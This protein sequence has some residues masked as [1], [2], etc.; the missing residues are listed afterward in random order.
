LANAFG[1]PRMPRPLSNSHFSFGLSFE[2]R[3]ELIETDFLIARANRHRLFPPK[4]L[5]PGRV[6]VTGQRSLSRSLSTS[7]RPGRKT[8]L[9]RVLLP[10]AAAPLTARSESD[11]DDVAADKGL[12][13]VERLVDLPLKARIEWMM[14]HFEF[15][16]TVA[17]R[18]GPGSSG[19]RHRPSV[20]LSLRAR[21]DQI[22]CHGL[23]I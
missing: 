23:S 15:S 20:R 22:V 12:Y 4:I 14:S 6:L 18:S 3:A 1:N 17:P 13:T 5:L 10:I 21:P 7:N 11:T 19:T 8:T 9:N 16:L 2:T